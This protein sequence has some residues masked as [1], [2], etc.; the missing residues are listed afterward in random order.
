MS[1]Q[2]LFAALCAVIAS[3]IIV[4]IIAIVRSYRQEKRIPRFS[5]FAPS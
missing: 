5:G 4:A 1:Y 2:V 3:N